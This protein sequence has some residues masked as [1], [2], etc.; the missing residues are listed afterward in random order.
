MGE[1]CQFVSNRIPPVIPILQPLFGERTADTWYALK[2]RTG[3][4]AS[5]V[6]ALQSRGLHPYCPTHKER[7]R[8]TDRMKVVDKPLFAG[9]VFCAFL[10]E[11]KLPIVS[12]PGVDYIVGFAGAATVIPQSQIE[13]IRR[14]V[15]AGA[16]ASERF[17]S[18]DRVRVTHGPLA[19]VEGILVREARGNR[20]VVSIELLNQAASVYIGQDQTSVIRVAQ[21][22]PV[23]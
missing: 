22:R 15:E 11:K 5:V 7:R 10:I 18:G 19:G 12:C 3:S 21:Q 23:R 6:N 13:N 14:M 2:V 9:Y 20:L 4:E 17:V 16:V 8:Y 1:A